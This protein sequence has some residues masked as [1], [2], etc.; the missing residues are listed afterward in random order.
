MRQTQ[1]KT[2][3]KLAILLFGIPLLLYNCQK[4]DDFINH[5]EN[6]SESEYKISKI[7]KS[8]I[9]ANKQLKNKLIKLAESLES[10]KQR[11]GNKT[12]VSSEFDFSI[13]TDYATYIENSDGTYHSYT[14]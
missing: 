7:G 14:F 1:I 9:Q 11:T 8:K 10:L 4:D 6:V 5:T 2:Y 13:N 3:L 12:V